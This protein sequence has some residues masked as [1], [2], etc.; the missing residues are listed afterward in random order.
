MPRSRLRRNLDFAGV[1]TRYESANVPCRG[2]AA[3]QLCLHPGTYITVPLA[4]GPSPHI[5]TQHTSSEHLFAHP[6]HTLIPLSTSTI[7]MARFFAVAVFAL[8]SLA[9]SSPVLAGPIPRDDAAPVSPGD[10]FTPSI[11]IAFTYGKRR[12]CPYSSHWLTHLPSTSRTWP[13]PYYGHWDYPSR[14]HHWH[15]SS[16]DGLALVNVPLRS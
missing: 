8:L 12:A 2:S 6:L 13:W 3:V 7:T 10:A 16:G 14:C 11:S 4:A 9:I 15:P 5:T 1:L